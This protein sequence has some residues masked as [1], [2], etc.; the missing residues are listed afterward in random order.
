[1]KVYVTVDMEG[2][3]GIFD[4][5][6]ISTG[7]HFR[8]DEG[9]RL[10]T[11]DV[12]AC[13]EGLKDAG[14]DEIYVRDAHGRGVSFLYE[15]LS[16]KATGYIVGSIGSGEERFPALEG[17]DAMIMLGGH[18][19]AGYRHDALLDHSY[20]SDLIQNLWL[21]GRKVGEMEMDAAIA[22]DLGIPT[23]MMSG[24]SAACEEIREFIPNIVTAETKRGVTR[25]GAILKPHKTCLELIRKSAA[26]A[27]RRM[28]DIQPLKVENPVT[29]RVEFREKPILFGKPLPALSENIFPYVHRIDSRTFEVYGDDC[30]QAYTRLFGQYTI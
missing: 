10:L 7:G 17:C 4:I 25:T 13:V 6:Q 8:Y 9:R 20:I 12:N 24:D 26:E 27:V 30:N 1:M 29:L 18:C 15:H 11:A 28:D 3:S 16:E 21:N 5:D 22:G 14:V 19:M 2:I 23:I